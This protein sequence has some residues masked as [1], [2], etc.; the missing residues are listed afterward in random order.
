MN[1]FIPFKNIISYLWIIGFK[2]KYFVA[3]LMILATFFLCWDMNKWLWLYASWFYQWLW[4][5]CQLLLSIPVCMVVWLVFWLWSLFNTFMCLIR[6]WNYCS[7]YH[8]FTPWV[9]FWSIFMFMFLIIFYAKLAYKLALKF[10]WSCWFALLYMFFQPIAVWVLAFWKWEYCG[11]RIKIQNKNIWEIKPWID[12]EENIISN[13]KQRQLSVSSNEALDRKAIILQE[14]KHDRFFRNAMLIIFAV[15]I[16]LFLIRFIP[17]YIQTSAILREKQEERRE[18]MEDVIGGL[19]KWVLDCDN[20]Y[21]E[22]YDYFG[23]KL[24]KDIKNKGYGV[25]WALIKRETDGACFEAY[26]FNYRDKINWKDVSVFDYV[27]A[28]YKTKE[29]LFRCIDHDFKL[30]SLEDNWRGLDVA[31]WCSTL[32][33]RMFKEYK[34]WF[35][36]Y[37][38]E[39]KLKD[40]DDFEDPLLSKKLKKFNLVITT[41]CENIFRTRWNTDDDRYYYLTWKNELILLGQLWYQRDN[42]E[43]YEDV[44]KDALDGVVVIKEWYKMN[45]KWEIEYV[46]GRY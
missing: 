33:D 23:S 17:S 14:K 15:L 28:D 21:D 32:Y 38:K 43:K 29:V 40:Y 8:S 10:W 26:N 25:N 36:A 22:L 7:L 41:S 34:H 18:K 27:I 35:V 3:L 12:S 16:W 9:F 46:W 31:K 20:H 6:A 11:M 4:I 44:I 13:D 30:F 24:P 45:D 5:Y 19:E 37:D 42:C 39:W 2:V 1:A